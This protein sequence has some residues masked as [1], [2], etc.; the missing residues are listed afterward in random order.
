MKTEETKLLE[1]VD[2]EAGTE[3]GKIRAP[4]K[5]DLLVENVEIVKNPIGGI[6]VIE[7]GGGT[8]KVVTMGKKTENTGG[9]AGGIHKIARMS[10]GVNLGAGVV[11]GLEGIKMIAVEGVKDPGLDHVTGV[12]KREGV[13]QR[14]LAEGTVVRVNLLPGRIIKNIFK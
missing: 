1:Q 10:T 12:R 11:I 13:H 8:K 14:A 7:I 5:S 2:L 3:R 9:K 4:T 6:V